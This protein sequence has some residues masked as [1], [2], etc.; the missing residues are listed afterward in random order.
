VYGFVH[1][2]LFFNARQDVVHGDD[3]VQVQGCWAVVLLCLTLLCESSCEIGLDETTSWTL[4]H[5]MLPSLEV[6]TTERAEQK[7]LL[8]IVSTLLAPDC[9]ISTASPSCFMCFMRS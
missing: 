8:Y 5:K 9:T 6:R 7:D 1:V 4:Q 2:V 3:S